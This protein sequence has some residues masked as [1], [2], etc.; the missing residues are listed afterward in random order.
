M[1]LSPQEKAARRAAF[2]AMSPAKKLEHIWGYYKAPILLGLIAL[3]VLG[4]VLV[5]QLSKKE[6]VL[7]LALVNVSFGEDLEKRLTADYLAESGLDARRY[8]ICLYPGLY[9]SDNADTLN[10]EYAYASKMKFTGTVG[11]K[12]LD[13]V[14]M[15]R[16]GYDLLSQKG[17]LLDLSDVLDGPAA[18]LLTEN[19]VVLSDNSLEVMLG[20]AEEELRVTETVPN[21][22]CADLPLFREAGFDGDLY[23]G[24][25]GNSPR[26]DAV[27]A[28]LNY[29]MSCP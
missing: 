27:S 3:F 19:E 17:Y 29:L 16:E 13:L 15:N 20:E 14:L 5:R 23:L 12:K 11:T 28:Y 9:L 6:P 4:S 24:V 25:V 18:A 10:H 2:E 22:L 26:L 21:A 8:E 7:Y 1:K